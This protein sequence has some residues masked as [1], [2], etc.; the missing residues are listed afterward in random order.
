MK[1]KLWFIPFMVVLV[2]F[3]VLNSA[4]LKKESGVR[5]V[6]FGGVVTAVNRSCMHDGLCTI[7]VGGREIIYGRG[8]EPGPWGTLDASLATENPIGRK[9]VVYCGWNKIEKYTLKGNVQYFVRE[10]SH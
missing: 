8:R 5:E 6:R 7:T 2:F 10:I 1:L 9:V 4:E 3:S